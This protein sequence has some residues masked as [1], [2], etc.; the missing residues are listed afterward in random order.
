MPDEINTIQYNWYKPRLNSIK[1]HQWKSEVDARLGLTRNV[2]V[3]RKLKNGDIISELESKQVYSASLT[4]AMCLGA[5]LATIALWPKTKLI[6]LLCGSAG[7]YM[8]GYFTHDYFQ[9]ERQKS[10]LTTDNYIIET[11]ILIK[12][13]SN[14][15]Y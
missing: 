10:Q 1:F 5:S 6:S 12:D 3:N 2:L 7:L 9:T 4:Q 13:L 15:K 8:W 14:D 11:A